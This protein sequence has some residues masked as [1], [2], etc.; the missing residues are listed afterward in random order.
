MALLTE[1]RNFIPQVATAP[2]S[3]TTPGKR[4]DMAMITDSGSPTNDIFYLCKT[5]SVS[6]TDGTDG[7]WATIDITPI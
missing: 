4:G 3:G 6:D 2:T 7:F 5:D 1:N